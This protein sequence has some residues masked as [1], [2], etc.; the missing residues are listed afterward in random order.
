LLRKLQSV[1]DADQREEEIQVLIEQHPQLWRFV[2]ANKPFVRPKM[3]LGEKFITDFI[4]LGSAHW[5]QTQMRTATFIELERGG[6]R[7]FNKKGDP[8]AELTH[9]IRQL[10]DW[11]QWVTDNRTYVRDMFVEHGWLEWARSEWEGEAGLPPFGF[12]ARYLLVIGRRAEMSPDDR[13]RLQGM[14]EDSKDITI[15]TYDVLLD[16]LLP[17]A[18]FIP[19]AIRHYGAP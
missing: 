12:V 16:G 15:V 2:T 11:K 10:R 3:K 1:L 5:S 14:N 8:S 4:V 6:C 17:E 13:L 19:W 7:L 9:G 18:P